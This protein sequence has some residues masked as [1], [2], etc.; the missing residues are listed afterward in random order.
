MEIRAIYK[1]G[2][3]SRV[4]LGSCFRAMGALDAFFTSLSLYYKIES[5]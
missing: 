4:A 2:V 1:A 3:L 5:Q